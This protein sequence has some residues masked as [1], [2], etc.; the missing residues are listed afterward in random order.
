MDRFGSQWKNHPEKIQKNWEKLV[1]ETDTVLLPGDLSWGMKE[2]EALVDLAFI[3]RLPGKKIITVGNHDYWWNS[4]SKLNAL[5]DNMI[6]VKNSHTGYEDMAICGS[7]GWVCPNDKLFLDQD[8]K[9]Y[10]REVNR[11]ALSLE[12]AAKAGFKRM[13]VMLHYPPT[14]D[15][16]EPSGFTQLI[17]S[18]PVCGVVY[19]HLHGVTRYPCSYTGL[20]D[21][22]HYHLVAADYLSFTPKIITF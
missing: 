8:K 17:H 10:N 19:G 22:V 12:S 15:K 6:F 14:N 13:L 20:V 11:L 2:E 5:Y 18:Y 1:K 9:L 4:T 3:H 21:G 7:R 16:K